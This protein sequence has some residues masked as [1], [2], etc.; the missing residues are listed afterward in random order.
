M[1][2]L[3][4][5]LFD[6]LCAMSLLFVV[7][8][9]ATMNEWSSRNPADATTQAE[10]TTS[11][12]LVPEPPPEVIRVARRDMPRVGY[13]PPP[14]S[15]PEET[16]PLA[17]EPEPITPRYEREPE[18]IRPQCTP[19]RAVVMQYWKTDLV[20]ARSLSRHANDS[21][22]RRVLGATYKPL[23]NAVQRGAN[24]GNNTPEPP[25]SY[26]KVVIDRHDLGGCNN[27]RCRTAGS[28]FDPLPGETP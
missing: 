1:K 28:G 23:M 27:G 7:G 11:P 6:A 25:E 10:A 19:T 24:G 21:Q 17:H 4:R 14:E 8:T 26:A 5:H 12:T 18:P 22:I 16:P 9:F 13:T 20:R 15:T 3:A 2:A